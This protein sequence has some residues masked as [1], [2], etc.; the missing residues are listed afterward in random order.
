MNSGP[1]SSSTGNSSF[2]IVSGTITQQD[3]FGSVGTSLTN[4]N[5]QASGKVNNYC[6]VSN[7]NLSN[8]VNA[9]S[10]H[11]VYPD[12]VANDTTG[13]TDMGV[14]SSGYAQAAYSVTG[15]NDSYL[16]ASAPTGASSSGDMVYAC[17]ATGT[18]N[19]HRWYTSGF[20]KAI[21]AWAM[22][23]TGT[24]LLSLGFGLSLASSSKVIVNNGATITYTVPAGCSYVNITT[25][26]ASLS[27]TFPAAS[28]AIDGLMITVTPSAIVAT[29]TWASA[30]ATFIA[31]PAAF[32]ANTP[33]RM[34]YD[35]ASLKWY[36][37]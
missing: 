18:S 14:C 13:F 21:T 36:L 8:G 37:S 5:M 17:D 27:M 28:A 24:G 6:Q 35:H 19:G 10:D 2:G 7:Q 9:S 23:L 12:N 22:K 32:S 31:A 29:V 25:S 11:I 4:P 3:A 20:N 15:P 16:F 34:I 26:A 33:V 1:S 30:G